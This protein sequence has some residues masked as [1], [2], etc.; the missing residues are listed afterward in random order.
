MLT[1]SLLFWCKSDIK[2]R[3]ILLGLHLCCLCSSEGFFIGKE[4]RFPQLQLPCITKLLNLLSCASA[5]FLSSAMLRWARWRV[6]GW[7]AMKMFCGAPYFGTWYPLSQVYNQ[8]FIL[9]F[10]LK[11]CAVTSEL[12]GSC[13]L[14]NA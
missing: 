1:E 13:G 5:K 11:G 4:N 10:M 7:G 8:L 2:T 3:R 9:P 6:A 12:Q 14:W